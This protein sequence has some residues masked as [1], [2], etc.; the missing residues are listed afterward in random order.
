MTIDIPLYLEGYVK[1]LVNQG[2]R[3]EVTIEEARESRSLDQNALFHVL[4]RRLAEQA[5]TSQDWMKDF[6]KTRAIDYGYPSRFE[7][8]ELV[9]KP[10]SEASVDDLM[11]LIDAC[12]FVANENGFDI[13]RDK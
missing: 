11:L 5:G 1:S 8:G 3:F 4:V 6:V 9:A 2:K 12:Y 7:N 13:R 10:T